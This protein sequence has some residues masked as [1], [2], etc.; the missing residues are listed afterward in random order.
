M[1]SELSQSLAKLVEQ[2]EKELLEAASAEA[3]EHIK[4]RYLGKKGCIQHYMQELRVA[5][6]DQ[7][8][9]LGQ[10]I[11]ECK[12]RVSE[13][14][15]SNHQRLQAVELEATLAQEA[16]DIS[17]PGKAMRRG[18]L[19][20]I[21]IWMRKIIAVAEE[22][23][24][25]VR[26]GPE[27]ESDWYNFGALNF[28][29]EHPARDMQDTFYVNPGQ[30]LRTHT[31]NT[32]VRVLEQ[33]QLPVRVCI[34]GRVY[35]NED[36]S[37]RS[38]L[39]FHQFELLYVDRDVNFSDLLATL[40]LFLQRLFGR[41]VAVR[42][43]PSYF[44]FVEPGLEADMECLLCHG[45]GCRVCK[46]SGWLEILGAGLVH[47]NVLKNSGISDPRVTGFAAGL[48]IERMVMLLHGISDI[49]LFLEN[50]HTFLG[51]GFP[52]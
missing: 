42:F 6:P 25:A 4:Q 51:H 47:P 8:P 39:Q 11:N 32:Q 1:S 49:R 15:E 19:H 9:V 37:A 31:S 36:V 17:L 10:M 22:M 45:Q 48:G 41:P 13:L 23:G 3:V 2:V 40:E 34:P 50:D 26:L 52:R 7:R 24:F 21:T 44:P 43:R 35:R 33:E 46:H 30:L 14:I 5:A 29:E 28:G 27:V 18:G 20:P 38:H 12:L 16:I